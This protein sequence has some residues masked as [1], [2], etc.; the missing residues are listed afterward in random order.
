MYNPNSKYKVNVDSHGKQFPWGFPKIT[1]QRYSILHLRLLKVHV[2]PIFFL[3]ICNGNTYKTCLCGAFAA[4]RPKIALKHI[5]YNNQA[6]IIK[7][8]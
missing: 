5:N 6:N 1:H 3:L 7:H 4:T 2:N 8:L